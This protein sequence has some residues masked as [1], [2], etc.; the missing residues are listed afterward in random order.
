MYYLLGLLMFNVLFYGSSGESYS[1]YVMMNSSSE[2][3]LLMQRILKLK[4]M[5][6]LI[7][8]QVMIYRSLENDK[9]ILIILS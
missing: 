3:V 5:H 4:V 6:R 8:F 2:R 1:A 9:R 7:V